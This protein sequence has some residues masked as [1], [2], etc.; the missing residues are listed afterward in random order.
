MREL[1]WKTIIGITNPKVSI[2]DLDATTI[3]TGNLGKFYKIVGRHSVI[4][5]ECRLII[6]F[7]LVI[8]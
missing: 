7:T 4:V 1:R 3:S 2:R 8:M 5:F 6:F